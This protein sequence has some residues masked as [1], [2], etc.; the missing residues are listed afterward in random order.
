MDKNNIKKLIYSRVPEDKILLLKKIGSLAEK[1]GYKVFVVGGFVR[2][3]ILGHS[4]LDI[5]LTVEGRAD[6]FAR[7]LLKEMPG[8]MVAHERFKTASIFSKGS[9]RIDISTARE[10]KYPAPA[11]LPEVAPCCIYSDLY[12][13]DF[14]I[15]ALAVSLNPPVFGNLTDCF[16]GM[17]DIRS[18]IIRVLHPKSF[19][20]DPTRVFRAVRFAQRLDFRIEKQTQ[21][22]MSEAVESRL[23][24]SLSGRRL[25]NEIHLLF[26]EPD[27]LSV[28]LNMKRYRLEKCVHPE[29][30]ITKEK[31]EKIKKIKEFI[32]RTRGKQDPLEFQQ[33]L[34][35]FMEILNGQKQGCIEAVSQRLSLSAYET[36]A[37]KS[38]RL[39][40]GLVEKLKPVEK[41]PPS[42][43]YCHLKDAPAELA[44]LVM[45]LS[46]KKRAGIILDAFTLGLK[47]R[48]LTT[49]RDLIAM[50]FKPGPEFE[51]ILGKLLEIKIDGLAPGKADELKFISQSFKPEEKID[52]K[53]GPFSQGTDKAD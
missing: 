40:D 6:A 53:T 4:V 43:V 17:D 7:E 35:Y 9:P 30:G 12:R 32:T 14:T 21:E 24:D 46:G 52:R 23:C 49:G 51:K 34:V 11:E 16:N 2:D 8:K 29:L 13:R 45:S 38:V 20:D 33:W 41:M 42:G 5:D 25:R 31:I 3:L 50:G 18:G 22:L 1:T 28:V 19:E 27:P 10:E 39:S 37:L 44:V 48:P 15:N 26:S 36:R 47:T